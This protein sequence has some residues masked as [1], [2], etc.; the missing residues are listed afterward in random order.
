MPSRQRL[1][2]LARKPRLYAPVRESP[3]DRRQNSQACPSR[4]VLIVQAERC[5]EIV[6]TR[7]ALVGTIAIFALPKES[8]RDHKLC[9]CSTVLFL[10]RLADLLAEGFKTGVVV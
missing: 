10:T 5:A 8:L 2:R 4:A 7:F 9:Q 1:D 3:L 6:G